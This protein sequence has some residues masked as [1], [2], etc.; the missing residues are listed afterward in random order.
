MISC[1]NEFEMRKCQGVNFW[2]ASSKYQHHK[3]HLQQVKPNTWLCRRL[4][5][6]PKSVIG[7]GLT[8]TGLIIWLPREVDTLFRMFSI[9]DDIHSSILG[10]V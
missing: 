2:I 10:F 3:H 4:L 1:S 7:R 5:R 6:T 8:K 9:R